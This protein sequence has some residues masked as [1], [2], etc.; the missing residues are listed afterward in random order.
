MKFHI[1][2]NIYSCNYCEYVARPVHDILYHMEAI[3]NIKG[4]LGQKL[5]VMKLHVLRNMSPKLI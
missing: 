3:H 4:R 5:H 1:T 2:D